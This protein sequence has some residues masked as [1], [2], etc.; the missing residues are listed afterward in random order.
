[1]ARLR[2]ASWKKKREA[3][4]KALAEG[5]STDT[6]TTG[7]DTQSSSTRS[8]TSPSAS[9]AKTNN[10]V[11]IKEMRPIPG[12]QTG[13]LGIQ[14]QDLRDVTLYHTDNFV[15]IPISE[16]NR[17]NPAGVP[18]WSEAASEE[19]NLSLTT[20]NATSPD[21]SGTENTQKNNGL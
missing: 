15:M 16:L 8:R 9:K 1:M 4:A 7:K 18:L 14:I 6:R 11:N 19:V 21:S 5:Q 13:L 17:L 10:A 12:H 20:T 3:L 2:T